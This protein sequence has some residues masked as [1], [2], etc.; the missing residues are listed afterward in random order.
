ML[1]L[2]ISSR[3]GRKRAALVLSPERGGGRKKLGGRRG[4][5]P[6]VPRPFLLSTKKR[7]GGFSFLLF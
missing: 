7:R 6:L 5:A 2:I 3:E 4:I 1:P